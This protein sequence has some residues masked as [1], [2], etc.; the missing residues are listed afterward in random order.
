MLGGTVAILLA[1]GL[2]A[3]VYA[4]F[5]SRSAGDDP[6]LKLLDSLVREAGE[7]VKDSQRRAA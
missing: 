7:E 6:K 2:L 3:A 5:L 4:I 1:L